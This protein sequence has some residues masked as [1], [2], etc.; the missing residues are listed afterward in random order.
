M[1]DTLTYVYA[2]ARDVGTV[3][4]L[5]GVG[6]GPVRTLE[7]DGVTAVVSDVD[8]G[9]FE[10]RALEERLEDLEWLAATARA[11]H[12]VVD[13]VGRDHLVAPLALATVYFDD[14]RV[15]SVLAEGRE[16]F[17][18]V[19][20]R[21]AGRAEWGIKVYARG[22]RSAPAEEDRPRSGA[23][24]LR[25][26]RK[27]LR[28][29][30]SALDDAREAAGQVDDAVTALA[31]ATRAHRLQD[32]Q[33]SGETDPMVL[34]QAYL[35]PVER[36]DELRALVA[37]YADHPRIRVELTGPWVPYSFA[38]AAQGAS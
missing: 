29:T 15:R 17:A 24:Y 25:A 22:R 38:Q 30:D 23:E 16:T 5:R 9:E 2:I 27:A 10:E 20:D 11:H 6:G 26:R 35:L 7:I 19:L 1:S 4:G 14:D 13:T 18:A 21:L 8:R 3:S 37:S 31:A 32:A 34:N 28:D 36:V 33:L 12:H